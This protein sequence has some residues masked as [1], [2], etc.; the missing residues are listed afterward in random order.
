MESTCEKK[1]LGEIES[2]VSSVFRQRESFAKA[3]FGYFYFP[4]IFKSNTQKNNVINNEKGAKFTRN[5]N[6]EIMSK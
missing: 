3:F 4:A 5:N 6:R 2:I 1:Y